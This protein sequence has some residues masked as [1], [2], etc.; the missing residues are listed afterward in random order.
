MQVSVAL[1]A[2]AKLALLFT[3][4]L[5]TAGPGNDQEQIDPRNLRTFRQLL[6]AVLAQRSTRLL[7]LAQ[8]ILPQR[9][10]TSVKAVA[11]GLGY[12]LEKAKFPLQPLA[13]RLLEAILR[14]LA[15]ER[16]AWYRGKVLVVIDPTDSAK[17]RRG[18]GKR[19]MQ[20]IGRVRKAGR[21]RQG[22]T[23]AKGKAGQGGA[24]VATAFG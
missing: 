7:T 2:R 9:R 1:R 10:A 5:H 19:Q 11:M 21:K 22:K 8:A 17:R 14:R 18:R 24:K 16:L 20:D 15:P 6:L 23:A 4:L 12:F 3:S 13:T